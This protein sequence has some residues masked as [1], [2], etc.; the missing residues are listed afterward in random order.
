[1]LSGVKGSSDMN[2]QTTRRADSRS[3]REPGAFYDER[4]RKAIRASSALQGRSKPRVPK[5][6]FAF[7]Y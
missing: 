2:S 3:G 7:S 5:V 1:M 6:L 4:I